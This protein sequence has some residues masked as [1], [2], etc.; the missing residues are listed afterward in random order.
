MNNGAFSVHTYGATRPGQ[1][2]KG[3]QGVATTI[4]GGYECIVT[5][6]DASPPPG[7][8]EYQVQKL[9]LATTSDVDH[10]C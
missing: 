10:G 1:T 5:L 7:P 9:L 4:I 2:Y 8:P 3:Y 6:F